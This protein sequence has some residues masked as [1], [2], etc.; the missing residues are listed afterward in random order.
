ML[1]NTKLIGMQLKMDKEKNF[2]VLDQ[3]NLIQNKNYVP[4]EVK[5]IGNK[6]K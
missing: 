3:R 1:F 2:R 5:I 6:T 4:K